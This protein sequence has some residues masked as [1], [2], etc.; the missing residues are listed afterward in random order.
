MQYIDM[1]TTGCARLYIYIVLTCV[2]RHIN[3]HTHTSYEVTV[4]H[5]KIIS[6]AHSPPQLQ[7]KGASNPCTDSHCTL[8]VSTPRTLHD[9]SGLHPQHMWAQ[10]GSAPAWWARRDVRLLQQGCRSPHPSCG[11]LI[12]CTDVTGLKQHPVAYAQSQ[13]KYLTGM[14]CSRGAYLSH[15]S[16]L[17]LESLASLRGGL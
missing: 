13:D 4:K 12:A 15:D 7:V 10:G 1:H 3:T 5:K 11:C 16:Q 14:G 8:S 9:S 2:S 17:V 6:L